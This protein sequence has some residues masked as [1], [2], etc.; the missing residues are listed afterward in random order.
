VATRTAIAAVSVP[1]P[2]YAAFFAFAV[3]VLGWD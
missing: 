2:L 1:V 3:V